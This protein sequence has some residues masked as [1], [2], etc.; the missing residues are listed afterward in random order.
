MIGFFSAFDENE[1]QVDKTKLCFTHISTL[2][3]S[4]ENVKEEMSGFALAFARYFKLDKVYLF[5]GKDKK[6]IYDYTL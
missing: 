4:E 1:K 2:D 6:I 5:Y 3:E